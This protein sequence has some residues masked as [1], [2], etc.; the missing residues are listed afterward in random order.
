MILEAPS[1]SVCRNSN[2][3]EN[4]LSPREQRY[5]FDPGGTTNG[6]L[7]NY[8]AWLDDAVRRGRRVLAIAY[9]AAE[10]GWTTSSA[11]TL[12]AQRP[13]ISAISGTLCGSAH[14]RSAGC[15]RYI[16]HRRSRARNLT[17]HCRGP[18]W[19]WDDNRH[20]VGADY[21]AGRCGRT[22]GGVAAATD[23][24]APS[25]VEGVAL[26]EALRA[27][28]CGQGGGGSGGG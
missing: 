16:L 14:A 4:A 21:C 18:A 20:P 19:G 26:I 7:A 6:D 27:V 9:T 5:S 1:S 3:H 8:G 15:G 12:R 23:A 25:T 10:A 28:C 2:N 17:A 22:G 24:T 13:A 11:D